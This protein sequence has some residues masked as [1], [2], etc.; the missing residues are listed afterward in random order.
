[1]R[2][3]SVK[4]P[5]YP[6]YVYGFCRDPSEDERLTAVARKAY[7]LMQP[8]SE[9]GE[10]VNFLAAELG[11]QAV[12]ARGLT[13]RTSISASWPSRTVYDPHNLFRLNHNISADDRLIRPRLIRGAP[14]EIVVCERSLDT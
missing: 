4:A 6:A 8:F 1:M 9:H 13:G 12:D 10:Y 11:D 5:R 14:P 3:P 7:A 2:F